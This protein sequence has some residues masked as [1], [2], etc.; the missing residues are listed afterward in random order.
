MGDGITI[1]YINLCENMFFLYFIFFFIF[2]INID[3]TT[4]FFKYSFEEHPNIIIEMS[5][6][7]T[8]IKTRY[9]FRDIEFRSPVTLSISL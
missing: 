5:K 1:T 7:V 8:F 6:S 9:I 4:Q 2:F 3:L